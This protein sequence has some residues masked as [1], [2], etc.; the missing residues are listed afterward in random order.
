MKISLENDPH[1]EANTLVEIPG[2]I[3]GVTINL[4]P[5]SRTLTLPDLEEP[6]NLRLATTTSWLDGT[7]RQITSASLLVNN[8]IVGDIPVDQLVE[9]DMEVGNLVF[10]SNSIA[11]R[12]IDDQGLS[13]SSSPIV[14]T[15]NEGAREVPKELQAGSSIGK[16]LLN[17][18]LLLLVLG[19]LG[20]LLYSLYRKGSL[21]GFS[22]QLPRG[23]SPRS[24]SH[25]PPPPPDEFNSLVDEKSGP[26]VLA[27]L[28]VLAADTT[29][30]PGKMHLDGAVVK[31]GRSPSQADLSFRED[32][33]VSRL[34]A[35]MMLE[36]GQYRIFD[37]NSTSGTYVNDVPVPE[38][39]V[40]LVDGDQIHLGAV[41]LRYHQL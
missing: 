28:E 32:I 8:Q 41:H 19:L 2:S 18:F 30:L 6:V 29:G 17:G 38:Y 9:F 10:G 25:V 15:V 39:G 1:V 4:P 22:G 33:T 26:F 5:E 3:P 31:L 20:W 21:S 34:H 13:A 14:L 24:R 40:Q 36:G 37:E 27:H 12:V 7:E 16:I 11:I 35:S 23:R